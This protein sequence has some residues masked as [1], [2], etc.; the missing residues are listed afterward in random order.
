MPSNLI[1]SYAKKTGLPVEDVEQKWNDAKSKIKEEY[2]KVKPESEQYYALLV[3][4]FKKMLKIKT[5][6]VAGNTTTS[7]GGDEAIYK[8]KLGCTMSR[9]DKIL[10]KK[11]FDE[12]T[13]LD[14]LDVILE[15]T[16]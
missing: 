9:I 8:K 10:K 6:E 5:E 13:I 1:N 16:K 3:S 14:K 12:G 7:V 4:I 15:E 11:K 2:P